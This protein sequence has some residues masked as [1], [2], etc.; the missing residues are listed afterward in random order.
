MSRMQ[1]VK[2]ELSNMGISIRRKPFE[3]EIRVNFKNGK[4]ETAYYTNDLEDALQTGRC[5]AREEKFDV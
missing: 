1:E 4:E 3:S 2:Q 5:M